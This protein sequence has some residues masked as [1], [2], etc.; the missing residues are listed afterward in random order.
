[1]REVNAG[2][3]CEHNDSMLHIWMAYQ[4]DTQWNNLACICTCCGAKAYMSS[5]TW[6]EIRAKRDAWWAKRELRAKRA[7]A[8]L[9]VNT[10]PERRPE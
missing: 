6:L 10:A 3:R 8:A 2:S 1:M 4:H 9:K 5:D 7:R